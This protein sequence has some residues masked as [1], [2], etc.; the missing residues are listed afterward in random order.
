MSRKGISQSYVKGIFE[1]ENA[2]NEH[3]TRQFSLTLTD[4]QWLL[5]E[6]LTENRLLPSL[7]QHL[8]LAIAEYLEQMNGCLAGVKKVRAKTGIEDTDLLSQPNASV[9]T[10]S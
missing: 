2:L 9:H 6:L 8:S 3:K 7:E 1:G 10:G 5:S 4:K